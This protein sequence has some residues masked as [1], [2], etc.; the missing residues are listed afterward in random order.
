MTRALL[1]C[2]TAMMSITAAFAQTYPVKP[3]H[4]IVPYPPGGGT[5]LLGR[6][7]GLKLA[8]AMGQQVRR[9]TSARSPA[10]KPHPMVIR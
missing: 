2:M 6:T 8:A 1:I 7:L 3:I 5:D 9:A 4:F 10:R